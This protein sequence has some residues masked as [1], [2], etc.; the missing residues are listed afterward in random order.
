M[1][2]SHAVDADVE[3]PGSWLLRDERI[4]LYVEAAD[5]SEAIYSFR[6]DDEFRIIDAREGKRDDV[7]G[8]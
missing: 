1:Y 2:N 7:A 6:T 8:S 4:N 5:G 3:F